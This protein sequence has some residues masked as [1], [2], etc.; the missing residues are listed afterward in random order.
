MMDD[1]GKSKISSYGCFTY[2]PDVNVTL[3]RL[4]HYV[5]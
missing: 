4:H 5:L 1:L 3:E 2:K